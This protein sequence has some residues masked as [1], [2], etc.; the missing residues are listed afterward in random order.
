MSD[1]PKLKEIVH[2][3]VEITRFLKVDNPG[4]VECR[5]VDLS[6][7]EHLF[8][9]KIP[10]VTAADIW[11]DTR[12]P[13]PGVIAAIVVKQSMQPSGQE[14]LTVDTA[15]PWDI[16]STAGETIF[17]IGSHQLVSMDSN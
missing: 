17:E 5:L 6:G 2:V 10:V 3:A 11:A 1:D 12:Y 15:E 9:E 8:H 7:R 4:W 14:S 16:E 13:Q